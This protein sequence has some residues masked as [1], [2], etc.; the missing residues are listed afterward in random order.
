MCYDDKT[1][2]GVGCLDYHQARAFVHSDRRFCQN[3]EVTVSDPRLTPA[4]RTFCDRGHTSGDRPRVGSM[5]GVGPFPD[6]AL[7]LSQGDTKLLAQK[8][9][10]V[11]RP[12]SLLEWNRWF[13]W[14][15]VRSLLTLKCTMHGCKAS[16]GSGAPADTA[17]QLNGALSVP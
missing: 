8:D 10:R 12:M 2:T 4:L 3:L 16:S 11:R 7:M 1:S 15:P 13:A 5:A 14:Y 17:A 6:V 9:S